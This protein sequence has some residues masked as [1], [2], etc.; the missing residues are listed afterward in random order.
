[1]AGADG[2]LDL[3]RGWSGSR[4]LEWLAAMRGQR[5]AVGL[6]FAFSFP[7]WWLEARGLRSG[8]DLWA[9]AAVQGERW[10]RDGEWPL[11][12]RRWRWRRP[13]LGASAHLRATDTRHRASSPFK[14]VGPDSVG[15]GSVRGMRLLHALASEGVAIWPFTGPGWPRVFEI[16]PR[17]LTRGIPRPAAVSEDAF[18]AAASALVMWRHR[19]ALA[20]WPAGDPVEGEIWAP[21]A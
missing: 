20:R 4:A 1:M 10:L 17:M 21:P 9:L 7:A 14:L 5:I 13:D 19:E 6:D 11:W 3:S 2:L 18:D 15:T 8:P 12:G 16:Y